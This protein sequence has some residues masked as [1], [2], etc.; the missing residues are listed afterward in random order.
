MS[1]LSFGGEQPGPLRL[2]IWVGHYQA[3]VQLVTTPLFWLL[4]AAVAVVTDSRAVDWVVT[5]LVLAAVPV[6]MVTFIGKDL[7]DRSLC[8]R[9]TETDLETVLDPEGAVNRN[10]NRLR[11][12][13]RRWATYLVGGASIIWAATNGLLTRQASFPVRL[14]ALGLAVLI[15]GAVLYLLVLVPAT[16]QRLRPWCPWC[17]WRDGGDE[18]AAPDPAPDPVS[19]A[20]R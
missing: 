13:H 8:L 11:W 6:I 19:H 7:H 2:L 4:P 15:T 10:R 17:H 5:V 3:R 18:E 14:G 9:D 12:Y 1:T 20:D 16:H